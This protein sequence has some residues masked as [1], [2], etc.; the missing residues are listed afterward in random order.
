MLSTYA[1]RTI[2]IY[3]WL[4]DYYYIRKNNISALWAIWHIFMSGEIVASLLSLCMTK[5]LRKWG[6]GWRYVL[7]NTKNA[8]SLITL[9]YRR[10]TKR[11]LWY[12]LQ[13]NPRGILIWYRAI[14]GHRCPLSAHTKHK[15]FCPVLNPAQFWLQLIVHKYHNAKITYIP[16]VTFRFACDRY[17]F[18]TEIVPNPRNKI[19]V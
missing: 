8:N 4:S 10:L 3:W 11:L 6:W 12:W 9:V 19:R 2:H 1:S 18:I 17:L 14:A 7:S 16:Q 5:W 15:S 13:M